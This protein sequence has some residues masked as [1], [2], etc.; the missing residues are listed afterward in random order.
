MASV[1][2]VAGG[3]FLPDRYAHVE[4]ALDEGFEQLDLA[5]SVQ[6][7]YATYW[8]AFGTDSAGIELCEDGAFMKPALLSQCPKPS[9]IDSLPSCDNSTY[10]ELCIPDGACGSGKRDLGNCPRLEVADSKATVLIKTQTCKGSLGTRFC[11]NL[12]K[13][14]STAALLTTLSG[15]FLPLAHALWIFREGA[16]DRCCILIVFDGITAAVV[17]S[18]ILP[19]SWEVAPPTASVVCVVF[20][21]L[22]FIYVNF[23]NCCLLCASVESNRGRRWAAMLLPIFGVYTAWRLG[24]E[25]AKETIKVRKP[26]KIHLRLQQDLPEIAIVVLDMLYF[27][28]SWYATVDVIASVLGFTYHFLIWA[29]LQVP[30]CCRWTIEKVSNCCMECCRCTK[31]R[32]MAAKTAVRE[33]DS[34]FAASIGAPTAV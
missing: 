27:G 19:V 25:L 11:N 13:G 29:L 6:Y 30:A 33:A 14:I 22:S 5:S 28:F 12:A 1:V 34:R 23:W 2:A 8:R 15:I 3:A 7:W 24:H 16:E 31:E 20:V 18:I 32:A 9:D 10:G 21:G 17:A 4:L 26:M